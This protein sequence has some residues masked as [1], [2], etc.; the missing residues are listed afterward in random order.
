MPGAPVESD[1][2]E[3]HF[4]WSLM[5]MN[6][7]AAYLTALGILGE[8]LNLTGAIMDETPGSEKE[9]EAKTTRLLVLNN[10]GAVAWLADDEVSA[11]RLTDEALDLYGSLR[12]EDPAYSGHRSGSARDP[13]TGNRVPTTPSADL[14]RPGIKLYALRG[15]FLRELAREGHAHFDAAFAAAATAID[16]LEQY[17]VALPG[18]DDQLRFIGSEGTFYQEMIT[19]CLLAAERRDVRE[20][21]IWHERAWVYAERSRARITQQTMLRSRRRR[22]PPAHGTWARPSGM[23][24]PEPGSGRP[25][26]GVTALRSTAS[27]GVMG[28]GMIQEVARDPEATRSQIREHEASIARVRRE[29]HSLLAIEH[30]DLG[31]VQRHLGAIDGGAMIV[32]MCML[33][34]RCVFFILDGEALHVECV[35][36]APAELAAL[37]RSFRASLDH[38]ADASLAAPGFERALHT[39]AAWFISPLRSHLDRL[40]RASS[41]EPDRVAHLLLVPAGD[42][43]L[44]PAARVA[45]RW[46]HTASRPLRHHLPPGGNES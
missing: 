33:A 36:V 18:Q 30:P 1:D 8:A 19:T 14:I 22:G 29:I 43:H 27:E 35:D 11:L 20:R 32:E 38:I 12:E 28:S 15:K 25:L 40:P 4:E 6:A 5:K 23:D 34:D 42:L 39:L 26:C 3:E 41:E 46:R 9:R 21:G 10:M 31:A 13:E 45:A 16:L 7:K 17:L 24:P 37:T 2:F 44:W